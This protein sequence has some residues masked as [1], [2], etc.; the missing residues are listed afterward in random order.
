MLDVS[1]IKL[2]VLSSHIKH[3]SKFQNLFLSYNQLTTLPD[4]IG[5]LKELV[6]L[7]VSNSKLSVF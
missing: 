1:K 5:D 2:S 3:L 6:W 4:D 7:K